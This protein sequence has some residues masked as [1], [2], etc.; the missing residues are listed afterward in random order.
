[1][2]KV[3]VG[4]L[5]LALLLV[6]ADV[7]ARL[8]AERVL[9]ST[10]QQRLSLPERPD[11][12]IGGFS[13]LVQAVSGTYDE[14]SVEARG[15]PTENVGE[16]DYLLTF[17]DIDLPLSRLINQDVSGTTARRATAE[18]SVSEQTL[19]DLAGRPIAVSSGQNGQIQLATT[20]EI[21]GA[22]VDLQVTAD[23]QVAGEQVVIDVQDVSAAGVS[24]PS[25]V[26]GAIADAIGVSFPLPPAIR[27]LTLTDVTAR[28]GAIVLHAEGSDVPLSGS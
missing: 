4:L 26:V 6:G 5:V 12:S 8:V 15:V 28:D 20:Y 23:V 9:A 13:V 25:S 17:Y 10:L 18:V 19:S 16:L 2:K 21:A 1:M 11:V 3:I 24:V 22:S 14:V 7:A 27:G